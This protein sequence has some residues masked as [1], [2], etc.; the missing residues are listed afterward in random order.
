ME[1]NTQDSFAAIQ[2]ASQ[3]D[4]EAL[5]S[6]MSEEPAEDEV[7]KEE[8][9]LSFAE[10]SA[11]GSDEILEPRSSIRVLGQTANKPTQIDMRGCGISEIHTEITVVPDYIDDLRRA[12]DAI[13][14]RVKQ[15]NS[16]SDSIGQE[17]STGPE[18]DRCFVC[19]RVA[20]DKATILPC[21]HQICFACASKWIVENSES[22]TCPFCRTEIV[23]V[24]H[25]PIVIETVERIVEQ[26]HEISGR[27]KLT[28][29]AME[30]YMDQLEGIEV[31]F[32]PY[33]SPNMRNLMSVDDAI[34]EI[35][36]LHELSHS[37]DSLNSRF[38]TPDAAAGRMLLKDLQ[39]CK[40]RLYRLSLYLISRIRA[41]EMGVAWD[42]NRLCGI[43]ESQLALQ[44]QDMVMP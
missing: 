16:T 3:T 27:Q 29:E 37:V 33:L 25:S 6:M 26:A 8:Q 20:V 41:L 7:H 14:G 12:R 17:D 23:E 19:Y 5:D 22:P 42:A 15:E 18:D 39:S 34:I 13:G 36:I 21:T 10:D 11:Y 1:Q 32:E 43:L 40:D 35:D 24:S 9:D 2:R 44:Q 31:R 30:I 4:E 38:P 28:E